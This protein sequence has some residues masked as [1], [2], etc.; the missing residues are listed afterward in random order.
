MTTGRINQVAPLRSSKRGGRDTLA[1]ARPP[2]Q[3]GGVLPDGAD[4]HLPPSRETTRYC[5]GGG[6]ATAGHLVLLRAGHREVPTAR[7]WPVLGKSALPSD[8]NTL[9][10][11]PA[12]FVS[13]VGRCWGRPGNTPKL[14]RSRVDVGS[15]SCAILSHSTPGETHALPNIVATCMPRQAR[16]LI[17]PYIKPIAATAER[18]ATVYT[19]RRGSPR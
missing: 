4:R 8:N 2:G 16:S 19:A 12:A 5:D 3:T 11:P 15:P 10:R 14:V 9:G 6:L 13:T 7:R 1:G 17:N 18:F